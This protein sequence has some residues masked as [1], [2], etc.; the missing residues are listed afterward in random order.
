M[1]I[2]HIPGVV[3]FQPCKR[4]EEGVIPDDAAHAVDQCEDIIYVVIEFQNIDDNG[5]DILVK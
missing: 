5:S 1:L 4:L 2:L 3:Q